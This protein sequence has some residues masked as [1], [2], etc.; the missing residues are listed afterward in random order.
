M[1]HHASSLIIHPTLRRC[2]V[3]ILEGE[4]SGPEVVR[5][6]VEVLQTVASLFGIELDLRW[7]GEIGVMAERS[8][9]VALTESV[10]QFSETV[11][12]DRGALLC[13]AGGGR[14][15][16]D[17]RA[18]FDLYYKFTP[19][20]PLQAL[21]Q[22]GPLQPSRLDHVDL[23]VVRENAGGLYFG[24]HR[25]T[26]EE[27]FHSFCYR[28]SEVRRLIEKGVQLAQQRRGRITLAV[29][30]SAIPAAS[31]LWMEVFAELV[32]QA[33][34]EANTLEIDNANYQIVAHAS[35]FD[36][37]VAPNLFGDILSDVAALLLGSRGMSFSGNF[38]A[39]GEATYQT[40][41]G[42]AHDLAGKDRANPVGQ[43]F[44]V[45][46][47]LRHS[48]GLP[49]AARCI[50]QAVETVLAQGF[51]TP[52]IAEAGSTLVGTREL[53]ERICHEIKNGSPL[54]AR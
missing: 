11:F 26:T 6:A 2:T 14:F 7:G 29:K 18:R 27:A 49:E 44:S 19:V 16:Y 3:G 41:H 10:I 17:M 35:Q 39:K 50:E 1:S 51:R 12:A 4:G 30:P 45:G 40:G 47:M 22:A 28:A 20:R 9:G 21:R 25:L 34:L 53:G 36:V 24:E 15:V 13:G 37:I 5:V 31:K 46:F 38:G 33:G 54:L 42:A 48:F 43:I 23:V 8:H 32:R 52:D